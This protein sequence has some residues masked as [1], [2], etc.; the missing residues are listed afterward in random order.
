VGVFLGRRGNRGVGR[1]SSVLS[2]RRIL[3]KNPLASKVDQKNLTISEFDEFTSMEK[4]SQL[5][6]IESIWPNQK[7]DKLG[8][9]PFFFW[10]QAM[11]QHLVD[12]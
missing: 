5:F 7:F 10:T 1:Y 3:I 8:T 4:C 11:A 9:Y 12:I 6:L 2:K